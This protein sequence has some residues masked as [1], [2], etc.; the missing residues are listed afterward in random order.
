M[1]SF[2][3][4]KIFNIPNIMLL[5]DN[6]LQLSVKICFKCL[7]FLR[8]W[9][10]RD[11]NHNYKS[12]IVLLLQIIDSNWSPLNWMIIFL[13]VKY[14]FLNLLKWIKDN[15]KNPC[16]LPLWHILFLLEEISNI[17]LALS[18][19]RQNDENEVG[20]TT[21]RTSTAP[22]SC[23]VMSRGGRRFTIEVASALLSSFGNFP[24]WPRALTVLI[25]LCRR[26]VAISRFDGI[27]RCLYGVITVM[28]VA[29]LAKLTCFFASTRT[30]I[31]EQR[32]IWTGDQNF[33]TQ[34]PVC[35]SAICRGNLAGGTINTKL[36]Q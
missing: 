25:R 21:T 3:F 31:L 26:S 34:T 32:Y 19:G 14:F 17:F 30:Q 29:G 23:A 20:S 8:I 4:N 10:V 13:N 1:A 7:H 6:V 16:G 15:S 24:N 33:T 35:G 27:R 28:S 9:I 5:K 22:T 2:D 18:I 11:F 12:L 36:I